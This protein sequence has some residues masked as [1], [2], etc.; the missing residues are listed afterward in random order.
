M[1][2]VIIWSPGVTLEAIEKQVIFKA[3]RFYQDNKTT[4]ADALGIALRT[5]HVKL[6]K[7]REEDKI[8]GIKDDEFR[9]EQAD[10]LNRHR[11]GQT[12]EAAK[13]QDFYRPSTGP[14]V[15]SAPQLAAQHAVPVQ[16][17]AQVQNVS[18]ESAPTSGAKGARRKV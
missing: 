17:R 11:Y 12:G 1:S 13:S 7:Y 14:R 3:L 6:E 8:E 5:L 15:E 16:E 9:R 18:S 4:T 10:R 2:D